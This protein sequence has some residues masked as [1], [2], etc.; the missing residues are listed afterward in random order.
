MADGLRDREG[1]EDQRGFK[2]RVRRRRGRDMVV[3]I[4]VGGV[5]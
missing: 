5:R 2:G 1:E 3:E 4:E